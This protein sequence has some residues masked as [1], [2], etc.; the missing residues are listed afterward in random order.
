MKALVAMWPRTTE[1]LLGVWL[2]VGPWLLDAPAVL[3][4][5][6]AVVGLAA[7]CI[8][9][10]AMRLPTRLVNLWNLVLGAWLVA[11]PLLWS[12][13]IHSA[14]AQN[15]LLVGLGL[16]MFA[17]IPTRC[18]QIPAA[19]QSYFSHHPE[20]AA[21]EAARGKELQ[22]SSREMSRRGVST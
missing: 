1:L 18:M 17:I 4:A 15:E 14:G 11:F 16:L 6:D 8:A 21:E 22:R 9:L 10:L 20:A 13:A 5:H 12:R 7:A 19:W 2:V 3:R